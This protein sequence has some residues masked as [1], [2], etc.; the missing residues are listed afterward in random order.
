MF[1]L[2]NSKREIRIFYLRHQQQSNY[3]EPTSEQLQTNLAALM[4]RKKFSHL[5]IDSITNSSVGGISINPARHILQT[6]AH[7]ARRKQSFVE[8]FKWIQ[9]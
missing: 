4:H 8:I 2:T 1:L 7:T 9:I 3:S 5:K 6:T